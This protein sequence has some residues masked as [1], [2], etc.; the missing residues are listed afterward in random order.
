MPDI[1]SFSE[2]TV[3]GRRSVIAGDFRVEL[4]LTSQVLAIHAPDRGYVAGEAPL[5]ATLGTIDPEAPVSASV[6]SQK[7][8]VF[9]D[10]L[11]AAVEVAAQKGAGRLSGKAGLLMSLCGALVGADPAVAGDVQALL[12]GAARLGRVAIP[13]LPPALEPLVERAVK[14]FLADEKRSKPIGFYTRS[15][16]L[17]S[18]FQQDR[19]LQGELQDRGSIEILASALQAEPSARAAYEAHL[20]LMSRLTN[21]FAGPDLRGHLA[22]SDRRI[23]DAPAQGTRFFPPSVAHETEIIKRLY[24]DKPI[25]ADFVLVDE[26]IRRIRSGELDLEPRPESGWYDHQTWALEPL[27]IPERMREAAYLEFGDEYRKLLLELFK[28][29]VTLTRETHI[30]QLERP[31]SVGCALGQAPEEVPLVIAPALAAEPLV[32]FYLRRAMGYRF[33]RGVLEEA[34]GT[35]Q[36]DHMHRVTEGGPVDASLEEE[37]ADIEALFA[38]AHVVVSRQLGLAPDG[39]PGAGPNAD[40]AAGRFA[41]W[42]SRLERDP[43]LG[44][45]LRAMVPVFYDKGRGKTKVWVFLGW[46]ERPIDVSF[47]RPP[48]A[49]VLDL[50]GLPAP[51]HPGI[52]WGFLDAR[53]AYPVT[54]ELYVDHILDRDEFRK[55]CDRCGTRAEILGRLGVPTDRVPAHDVK[56]YQRRRAWQVCPQCG[57]QPRGDADDLLQRQCP[58]CGVPLGTHAV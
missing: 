8:K 37:L 32:T 51:R 16:Q 47:A 10:G 48:E 49:T 15:R 7:A 28:G 14:E 44:R 50:K 6:L 57:W 53:L 5:G 34:F 25:P 33:V 17:A 18:I 31:D 4:D 3:A 36:L 38:G 9:D 29:L 52:R 11:Y 22:A 19:M 12:L 2:F 26:M 21:P 27:V 13:D 41:A 43:D 20:R 39:A 56:Q 55:L 23:F 30:K 24:G 45:D 58:R 42:A 1:R 54:A 46:S 40:V 35:G